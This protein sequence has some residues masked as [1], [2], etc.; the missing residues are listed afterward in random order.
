MDLILQ[1]TSFEAV[2]PSGGDVEFDSPVILYL[3]T[4]GDLIVD[5][6]NS[7][8]AAGAAVAAFQEVTFANHPVGYFPHLVTKIHT[9][10]GDLDIVALHCES[11]SQESA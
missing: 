1:A 9:A 10:T 5:A 3:G 11:T 4:S 7:I 8:N 6:A 2:D